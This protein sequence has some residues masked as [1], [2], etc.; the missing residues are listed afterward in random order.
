MKSE[1]IAEI[2]LKIGAVSLRPKKPFRYS[3]GILSPIY[4]DNRLLMGYPKER[5]SIVKAMKELIEDKKI[6]CEF[7]SGTATAAIPHAAW[8]ADLMKKPMVYVRSDRK[9]HGKENQVEGLI[10]QGAVALNVEDLISTGGSA[11]STI[12][13]LRNAGFVAKDCVAIFTYEMKKA[14]EAFANAG[15]TLHALTTFS[16]LIRVAKEK[17]YISDTEL[18]IAK[19]WNNDPEN[20]AKRFGLEVS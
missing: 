4:T 1:K 7:I 17:G 12:E 10:K 8:L 11:I 20:W 3:S 2:L 6:S 5:K 19:E 16:T 18:S 15:V 13:T 14:S 9:D